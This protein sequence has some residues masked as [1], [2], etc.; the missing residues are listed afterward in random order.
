M[1]ICIFTHTFPRFDGDTAAPFM[2]ELT[3]AIVSRG[4]EVFVLAPYESQ[5]KRQKRPYKL[6]TYKYI[7]PDKLHILGY[8]RT[9]EGDKSMSVGA[10]LISPFLYFFGF[11]ALLRLVKKE[12]LDVISSHWILPN[13]FIASLVSKITG[14]AFTTT[15]P[16]SDVYMGGKNF[17]FR[18]MLGFAAMNAD[19]VLS[20]SSHYFDQVHSLGFYP[21]KTRVIR[22]GVNTQKFKPEEKDK[23]ILRSLGVDEKTPLIL[24]VGRMVAKKGFIYL[25]RAMP[26]VLRK[27]RNVK[28]V[29]VGDGEER[30]TL[31]QEVK[32]LNIEN[33][34]LFPGTIPYNILSKY[35]N[36]AD[37]F[38]MPS[39][40]DEKGNLDASPVSM[41]EAMACGV[42][43]IAT[44]FAGSEDLVVKGETGFLVKEKDIKSIGEGAALLLS[45]TDLKKSKKKVRQAALANFSTEVVVA[46]YLQI[47]RLIVKDNNE[48]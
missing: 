47:F 19:Y 18:W 24:A 27:I 32:K 42:P 26:Y 6:V 22:Y 46:K 41:M 15:I 39:I 34:V 25:I 5:I 31:E 10:Y 33:A 4:H 11:L 48:K 21:S 29:I 37:V 8:S 20:D 13:G 16:G 44:G 14:V 2:G 7:F 23:N 12:R 17:F 40:K 43:V 35:Y 45:K 38:V 36:I 30:Q 28:L 1:K 3:Q 9:L